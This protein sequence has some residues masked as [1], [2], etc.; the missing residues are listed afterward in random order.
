[1]W[2]PGERLSE[3]EALA[4]Y[5]FGA[6]YAA[7]EEGVLGVLRAGYRADVSAYSMRSGAD[8]ERW[9]TAQERAT[10]VDGKVLICEGAR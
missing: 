4:A 5:T 6:A 8:A 2:R 9:R 1:G 7:H 10:L 3:R